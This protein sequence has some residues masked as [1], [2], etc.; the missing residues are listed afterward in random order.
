MK[1]M[2]LFK[3][4]PNIFKQLLFKIFYHLFARSLYSGVLTNL[5]DIKLPAELAAEIESF[6]ILPANT[7]VPGRNSALFSYKGKLEMNIGSSC[8]DTL[9]EEKVIEKLQA[10][11]VSCQVIYN[12]D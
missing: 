1:N 8:K 12:R 4:L 6:D 3:Y 5:G 10:E 11:G 2:I 9:F 7:P